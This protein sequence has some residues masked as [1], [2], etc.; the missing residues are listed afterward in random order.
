MTILKVFENYIKDYLQLQKE[1]EGECDGENKECEKCKIIKAHRSL[2][3][4][5]KDRLSIM[6]EVESSG[7]E[8]IYTFLT[9][10]YKRGTIIRPPKDVDFFI[11][12]KK[13]DYND[14]SPAEVLNLLYAV[15]VDI[16][17]E[18]EEKSIRIQTHSITIDYE[19]GFGIDVI[20]AF[21][22]GE[23]YRIP[24]VPKD[25]EDWLISNPKIHTELM[26]KA[27]EITEGKLIS[28]VKLIKAWKR[29][30][31]KPKGI[32]VRSFHLEMLALEL[33][34][35]K[36]IESYQ[37]ALAEFFK[38]SISYLQEP[39]LIDPANKDNCIDA[40]LPNDSREALI[41][42][43]SSAAKYA[44][45]ALALEDEEK[46][47]E[48]LEEWHKIFTS[49]DFLKAKN[50][51]A[52]EL[53]SSTITTVGLFKTGDNSSLSAKPT[54]YEKVPRSSSWGK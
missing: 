38:I 20:P 14:F 12:L 32:K 41:A 26:Q 17:P 19:N 47:E 42:E 9:G 16:F 31:C 4:E 49:D 1:C 5:L 23:N 40:D 15:V 11:V 54:E 30:V 33:L 24:H 27:N 52:A 7:D 46:D 21:E 39:C 50:K 28:T 2:R 51:T 22:D 48:A 45:K 53:L 3:K 18:K 37:K 44:E 6:E 43:I 34:G 36:K 8:D 25:D 10:S 29:D 13:D 35:D